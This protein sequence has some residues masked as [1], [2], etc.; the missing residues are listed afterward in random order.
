MKTRSQDLMLRKRALE[1]ELLVTHTWGPK[2][3]PLASAFIWF[4]GQES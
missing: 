4:K 3:E 2:A 1:K